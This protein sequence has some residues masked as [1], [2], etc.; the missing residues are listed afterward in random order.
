MKNNKINIAIDGPSG[1][2]KTIMAKMLAKELGYRFISSGNLYR[3]VAYNAIQKNIDLTNENKINDAW[4]FEHLY[5]SKDEKV[6]LDKKDISLEIRKDEISQAA[7]AIAKFNSIRLKINDYIQNIGNK[8]K[9]IIVEGRDATYRILP[10]AE[11]KFFLWAEPEI[12]AKRRHR[13]NIILG[14]ESNLDE[15]LESIKVRDYND[16][17]R[18]VDPLKYTEGSIRIDSTYMSIEE[19]F[20]VMLAEVL[21]RL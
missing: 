16:M 17:N 21:K 8:D 9:G 1:V 3:A 4:N 18:K 19:N 20:R 13:Q 6:Y 10:D 14:I 2:G 5:I 7:S 15:I 12:R 11:V